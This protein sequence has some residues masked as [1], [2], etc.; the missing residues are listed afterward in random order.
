MIE[1]VCDQIDPAE[2]NINDAS[3]GITC[4]IDALP[5]GTKQLH[6]LALT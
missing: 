1:T 3:D 6:A 5:S 4:D 2:E